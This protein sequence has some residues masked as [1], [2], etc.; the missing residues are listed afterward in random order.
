MSFESV[1]LWLLSLL[2]VIFVPYRIGV[3][4]RIPIEEQ[5]H[6]LLT[7]QNS[8]GCDSGWTETAG[9]NPWNRTADQPV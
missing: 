6:G 5:P 8:H 7:P 3:S 1:S 9:C 4:I 2:E